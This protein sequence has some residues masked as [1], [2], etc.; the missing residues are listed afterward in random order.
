MNIP[1]VLRDILTEKH[2]V[3]KSSDLKKAVHLGDELAIS[4]L[5]RAAYYL[6]AGMGNLINIFNPQIVIL[7]GG[8]LEALEEEVLTLVKSYINRF[9]WPDM[10][11]QTRIKAAQLRDDAVLYGARALITETLGY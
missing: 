7:G 5:Q 11:S 1:T 9:A 8:V 2:G 4:T 6:A 10:L 3:I